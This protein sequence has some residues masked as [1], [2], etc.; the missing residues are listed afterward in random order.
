MLPA[1]APVLAALALPAVMVVSAAT[2]EGIDDWVLALA[3]RALE[4]RMLVQVREKGMERQK[5]QHL[6][7]RTLTRAQPFG[8][9]IV[10]N[11]DCGSFPQCDGLHLTAKA[12]MAASSRPSVSLVGASCHDERELDHAAAIGVDYVVVGPV[13]ATASHRAAAPLGWERFAALVKDRPM[14]AYAIGGL[15]RRDLPQAKEHGA[16]GVALM[17][18]AFD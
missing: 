15:S 1:N 16:H 17:S 12:L 7:S 5:L 10:V 18:A 11:S 13:N 8:S 3:A 6:L 14:P 4:E 2:A 9:R